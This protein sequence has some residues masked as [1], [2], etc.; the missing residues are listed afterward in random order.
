[1]PHAPASEP[2]TECVKL[3]PGRPGTGDRRSV[4]LKAAAA[5]EGAHD[6]RPVR[7]AKKNQGKIY[8][9]YTNLAEVIDTKH[10]AG[11][12]PDGT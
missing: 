6:Q 10:G 7:L 3:Q 12:A 5:R 8:L 2:R 1:M 11:N 9:Q 4:L